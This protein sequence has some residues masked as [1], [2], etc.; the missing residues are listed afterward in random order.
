M[1]KSP[2]V[3]KLALAISVLITAAS[4]LAVW[5]EKERMASRSAQISITELSPQGELP[6][7]RPLD[8]NIEALGPD[9][10]L[11]IEL[12]DPLHQIRVRR[13]ET[14]T[15]QG[16]LQTRLLTPLF[17]LRCVDRQLPC[18]ADHRRAVRKLSGLQLE[19]RVWAAKSRALLGIERLTL[20]PPLGPTVFL[21]DSSGVPQQNF[22]NQSVHLSGLQPTT[23][24]EVF[25][26]RHQT[27]WNVGDALVDLRGAAQTLTPNFD[28][29]GAW[30][31]LIWNPKNVSLGPYDVVVRSSSNDP[32]IVIGHEQFMIAED[33]VDRGSGGIVLEPWQCGD[34]DP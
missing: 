8:L 17:F 7:D 34:I 33:C 23:Q 6:L 26:V 18:F 16:E 30:T 15:A 14:S 10:R 22:L 1:S 5:A 31:E 24:L 19:L 32:P 27:S 29:F 13:H 11:I 28:I 9:Q 25:I 2:G 3:R 20:S 21:S 12:V 4:T